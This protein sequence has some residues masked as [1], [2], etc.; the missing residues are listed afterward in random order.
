VAGL[1]TNLRARLG[2]RSRL[3]KR[4]A[5]RPV[6]LTGEEEALVDRVIAGLG[7]FN[8]VMCACAPQGRLL[9]L[10][11]VVAAV[12]PTTPE[13]SMMNAVVYERTSA[14]TAALDELTTTYEQA[15]VENWMVTVPATDAQAK[16][17]LRRAGHRLG[18]IPTGMARGLRGI[19]RPARAAVGEWTAEGEPA[20][21]A[22]ICDRAFHFGGDFA[23]TFS[24]P[25]PDWARVYLASL[26]AEP[27]ACVLTYE[28]DGNC[29]VG[30]V[31]TVEEARGHGLGAAL[32]AHALADAAERGC[33]TTTLAAT[34][35]GRPGFER[36]GYRA[37]CPIQQ[38]EHRS[39]AARPGG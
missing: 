18:G 3:R 26:G 37:L 22:A 39:A 13:R 11:G 7:D 16:K 23:R 38:W 28:R 20:A 4:L 14:L 8:R 9:E 19:E 30:P 2:L 1:T 5:Q 35:E 34:P 12:I 31:A 29:G 25:L 27:V 24:R 10:D 6:R 32:L 17:P 21:M 33:T 15:G 36:L